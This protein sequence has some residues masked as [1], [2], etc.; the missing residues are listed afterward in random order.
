MAS[1]HLLRS[2]AAQYISEAATCGYRGCRAV[3]LFEAGVLQVMET[4]IREIRGR[5]LSRKLS[6]I[7]TLLII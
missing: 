6:S 7:A 3:Q 2:G 5:P 1:K 4:E